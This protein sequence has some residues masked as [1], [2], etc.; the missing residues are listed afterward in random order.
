MP[1]NRS[2]APW[3]RPDCHPNLRPPRRCRCLDRPDL[4][5]LP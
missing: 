3:S 1:P 5:K 2:F 4:C